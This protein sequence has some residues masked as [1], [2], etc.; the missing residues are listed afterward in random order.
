[1]TLRRSVFDAV[2]GTRG[3]CD[4]CWIRIQG[5]DYATWN[6]RQASN[7]SCGEGDYDYRAFDH[8]DQADV[9]EEVWRRRNAAVYEMGESGT[10]SVTSSAVSGS[11]T[12]GQD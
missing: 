6:G 1:M 11:D 12:F 4:V 3:S 5:F 7:A 10:L 9:H 2:E 8:E